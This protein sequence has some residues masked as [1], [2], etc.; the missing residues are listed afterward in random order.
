MKSNSQFFLIVDTG[1]AKIH[2]ILIRKQIC[3]S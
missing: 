2:V 1:N 3:C